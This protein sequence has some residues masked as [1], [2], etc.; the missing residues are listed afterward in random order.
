MCLVLIYGPLTVAENNFKDCL[1]INNLPIIT[2][3]EAMFPKKE[4]MFQQL[5]LYRLRT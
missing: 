3:S 1:P 2:A 4:R 5:S